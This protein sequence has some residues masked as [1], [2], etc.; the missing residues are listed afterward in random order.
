MSYRWMTGSLMVVALLASPC[1]QAQA[2]AALLGSKPP[3]AD[4][5]RLFEHLR[6]PNRRRGGPP[7]LRLDALPR[8][9]PTGE[10]GGAHG[11]RRGASVPAIRA[12]R[13][14]ETGQGAGPRR[15]HAAVAGRREPRLSCRRAA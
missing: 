5:A 6:R 11:C 13:G 12:A 8:R 2:K 10:R 15:E 7:C 4:F 1:A 14:L 3:E 9:D